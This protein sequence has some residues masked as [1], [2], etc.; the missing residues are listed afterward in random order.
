MRGPGGVAAT[1]PRR[2]QI[3][4]VVAG[5]VVGAVVLGGGSAA[6]TGGVSLVAA[7]LGVFLGALVVLWRTL[8]RDRAWITRP[9]LRRVAAWSGLAGWALG[10]LAYAAAW[11]SA[12][13]LY[14]FG[15]RGLLLAAPVVGLVGGLAG[16]LAPL[17]VADGVGLR[18]GGLDEGGEIRPARAAPPQSSRLPGGRRR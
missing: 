11:A 6:L 1:G 4:L 2:S 15:P 8:G 17:C 7:G 18:T 16:L 3:G 10:A 5:E 12:P 9:A 13:E 14:A